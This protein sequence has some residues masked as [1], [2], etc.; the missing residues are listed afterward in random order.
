M[1]SK[2]GSSEVI[3]L[4]LIPVRDDGRLCQVLTMIEIDRDSV[5]IFEMEMIQQIN[6]FG[7]V[8]RQKCNQR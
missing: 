3:I 2:N 7:L 4:I 1:G 6:G 5:Y 8:V